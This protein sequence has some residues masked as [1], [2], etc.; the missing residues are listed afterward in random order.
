MKK[1]IK[2]LKSE[3][4]QLFN[5]NIKHTYSNRIGERAGIMLQC[6]Q[7]KIYIKEERVTSTTR[8]ET[9]SIENSHPIVPDDLS[10]ENNVPATHGV[11]PTMEQQLT[12]QTELDDEP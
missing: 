4:K 9:C 6:Y 3:P 2:Q 11:I 10:A 1:K 5:K 8:I 12:T 7:A